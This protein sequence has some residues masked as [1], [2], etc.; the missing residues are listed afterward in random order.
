V[1]SDNDKTGLDLKLEFVER[2]QSV[3][4]PVS[5]LGEIA[6]SA[7]LLEPL[8]FSTEGC[9]PS[10]QFSAWQQHMAPLLDLRLPDG[11]RPGEGFLA[12][13]AV[14]DLGGMLL[15]QQTAPAFSYERP[16]EKVRF[17]SIDH[18]QI[19]F[20]RSGHSWTGVD[21]RVAEN[22]PGMIDVRSAIHFGGGPLRRNLCPLS[23][24]ST[25]LPAVAACRKPAIMSLWAV[26]APNC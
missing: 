17:S 8:V 4:T 10:E 15:I 14:W 9:E 26:I 5:P 7:N 12:N 13:Q 24:L 23:F 6:G 25:S 18:W 16:K 19:S 2:R 3:R 11:I 21:G 1:T 20:L 22:E